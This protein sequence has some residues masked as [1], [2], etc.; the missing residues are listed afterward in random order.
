MKKL[1]LIL[2]TLSVL[3]PLAHLEAKDGRKKTKGNDTINVKCKL[4][5]A[6]LYYGIELGE[7]PTPTLVD[8]LVGE[9][10]EYDTNKELDLV[11]ITAKQLGFTNQTNI[12]WDEILDSAENKGYGV[13]PPQAGPEFFILSQNAPSQ[14]AYLWQRTF[15]GRPIFVGMERIRHH[16]YDNKK[17]KH[18]LFGHKN[19]FDYVFCIK[20]NIAKHNFEL[21]YCATN[22]VTDTKR[23]TWDYNDRF[24]FLRKTRTDTYNSS[25]LCK[26]R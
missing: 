11:V 26:S 1:L 21:G 16:L 5:S 14:K 8:T 6:N 9:I 3:A 22:S 10:E 23:Y 17:G 19:Y 13:C 4:F 18:P 25:V 12:T 2:V 20:S 24:I 15:N 7:K